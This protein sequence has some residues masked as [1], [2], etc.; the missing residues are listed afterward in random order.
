MLPFIKNVMERREGRFCQNIKQ[1]KRL[2]T[3][4][5]RKLE[6]KYLVL[7]NQ[8]EAAKEK[9]FVATETLAQVLSV[10]NLF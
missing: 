5:S 1:I 7:Q 10:V 4:H 8:C 6:K 9:E 3:Y 2:Q